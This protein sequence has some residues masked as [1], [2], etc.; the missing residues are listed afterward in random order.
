M[1]P[2]NDLRFAR[3]QAAHQRGFNLGLKFAQ[4][5]RIRG[6]NAFMEIRIVVDEGRLVQRA[7]HARAHR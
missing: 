2:L 4:G 6:P 5:R 1:A 7:H 3:R